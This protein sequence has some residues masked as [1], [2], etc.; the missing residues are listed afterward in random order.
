MMKTLLKIIFLLLTLGKAFNSPA[1]DIDNYHSI[2]LYVSSVPENL[3]YQPKLL[4]EKLTETTKNDTLKVRAIYCWIAHHIQY[5]LDAL[6]EHR[7]SNTS[8]NDVLRNG[9]ALC[10]GFAVLF[11]SMCS[12]V[13]IPGVIIEGYAKINGYQQGQV[14]NSVNHAW[15]AVKLG[16]CWQLIDVT[17]ATGDPRSTLHNSQKALFER[18]FLTEPNIFIYDHLPADPTW[19]LLST[20]ITLKTFNTGK[21]AISTA[22][23]DTTFSIMNRYHPSDY[24]NLSAFDQEIVSAKRSMKFNPLNLDIKFRLGNAYLFKAISVTDGLYQKKP[25]NLIDSARMLD[26]LFYAYLDSAGIVYESFLNTPKN[27]QVLRMRD[28]INYQKGVYHY[29]TG[30]DVF[31]KMNGEQ[32]SLNDPEYYKFLTFTNAEFEKA[33]PFFK[34][35]PLSSLYHASAQ[36]YIKNIR[37]FKDR[38][39]N[40]KK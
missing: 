28:E 21:K 40:L 27:E 13:Q 22:L 17:W 34:Q 38:N 18:Y 6:D 9:K 1:Q 11:Q 24:D 15:N 10:E 35:V 2:D 26:M 5:D 39:A 12:F 16:N 14:L 36:E 7:P 8:I 32:T 3:I 30:S 4:A 25:E 29:E 31:L 23:N 33:L 37:E 19:Q 20:K